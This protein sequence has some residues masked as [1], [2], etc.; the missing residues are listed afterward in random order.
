MNRNPILRLSNSPIDSYHHIYNRN[1]L[2]RCLSDCL[3][4]CC[5]NRHYGL[6]DCND[7]FFQGATRYYFVWIYPTHWPPRLF[8]NYS[9]SGSPLIWCGWCL[10]HYWLGC[11]KGSGA[12]LI[13]CS[14]IWTKDLWFMIYTDCCACEGTC[15]RGCCGSLYPINTWSFIISRWV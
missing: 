6:V 5:I 4:L 2:C 1:M 9:S 3:H 7:S 10:L 8:S 14:L 13:H 15:G 12:G 11:T